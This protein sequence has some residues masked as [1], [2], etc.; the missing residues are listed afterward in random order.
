[1][2]FEERKKETKREV[3]FEFIKKETGN[4]ALLQDGWRTIVKQAFLQD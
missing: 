1:M 4:R 2:L 3:L